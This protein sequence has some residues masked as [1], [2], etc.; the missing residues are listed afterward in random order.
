[1]VFTGVKFNTYAA[2]DKYVGGEPT[3]RWTR[4]T[5]SQINEAMYSDGHCY[6]TAYTELGIG[7]TVG[8]PVPGTCSVAG[9]GGLPEGARWGG[10]PSSARNMAAEWMANNQSE[11]RI[12]RKTQP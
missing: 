1:M 3:S 4:P 5:F 7:K 8:M 9:W 6:A 12:G 11:P 2:A 10:V